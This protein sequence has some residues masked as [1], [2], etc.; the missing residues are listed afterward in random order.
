MCL[1]KWIKPHKE[2]AWL[3]LRF[4]L[5]VVFMYHGFGKLF[6]ASGLGDFANMLAGLGVPAANAIAVVVALVEFGGGILMLLGLFSRYVAVL[7]TVVMLVAIKTVHW[8]NGFNFMN[9][10]WEFNFVLIGGL[11][12]IL[13]NGPGIWN[14]EKKLFGKE[15]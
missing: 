1:A 8:Q 12:A 15:M 6:G 7:Q 9:G 3:S 5:A 10:G 2:Y 11:I 14:L 4:V 13:L